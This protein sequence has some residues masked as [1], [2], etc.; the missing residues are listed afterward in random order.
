MD[1]IY[2]FYIDVIMVFLFLCVGY[3]EK[4]RPLR[5]YMMIIFLSCMVY[6]TFC[7]RACYSVTYLP[8]IK[9]SNMFYPLDGLPTSLLPPRL[10]YPD[11][12]H[13]AATVHQP[14]PVSQ[15]QRLRLEARI[16]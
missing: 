15:V 9:S 7:N 11:G 1:D 8:G 3:N 5:A 10:S 2:S 16:L 13:A 12:Y 14:V 6:F 4:H